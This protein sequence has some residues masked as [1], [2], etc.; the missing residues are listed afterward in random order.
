[1]ECGSETALSAANPDFTQGEMENAAGHNA[2]PHFYFSGKAN[3]RFEK[4]ACPLHC[5]AGKHTESHPRT[6]TSALQQTLQTVPGNGSANAAFHKR[7]IQ[8]PTYVGK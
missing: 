5:I 7:D 8:K 4:R 6:G 3:N 1:M 2:Y